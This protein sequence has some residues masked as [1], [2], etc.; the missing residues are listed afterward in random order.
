MMA[1]W[2]HELAPTTGY[3]R[4]GAPGELGSGDRCRL[5]SGGAWLAPSLGLAPSAMTQGRMSY[6]LRWLHL[7]GLIERVPHT[8]SYT[9]SDFGLTSALF[10]SRAYGRFLLDGLADATT[11]SF[12]P[13]PLRKALL[14]VSTELDRLAVRSGLAA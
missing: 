2:P 14:G 5:R 6:H 8:H 13:P 11:A 1:P 10:S 9:V 12:P 3:A 4:R 7:H